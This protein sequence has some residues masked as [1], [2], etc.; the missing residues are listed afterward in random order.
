MQHSGKSLVLLCLALMLCACSEQSSNRPAWNDI[1]VIRE[2][3]EAPR[4]HFVAYANRDNALARNLEANE[5]HRS[6]NGAWKFSY[7]DSPAGRPADFYRA[8]FD[9]SGWGDIPVP[10]NWEREGHGYAIYVNVPY[11]FE[12]DEPNVPEVENPVGSYRRDFE[13][14]ENWTGRVLSLDQWRVCRLQRRQQ[15]AIRVRRHKIRDLGYEHCCRGSVPLEHRQL[16][17]GPGFLVI[18]RNPARCDAVRA[19]QTAGS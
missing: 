10:S 18:E 7:S 3:T 12:I 11:P 6:L 8:D 14:P 13:V 2:N 17:G 9:V 4:A 19:T 15:D 5:W 16:P 1:D